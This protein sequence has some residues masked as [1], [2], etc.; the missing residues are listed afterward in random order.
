MWK[1]NSTLTIFWKSESKAARLCAVIR[2]HLGTD[3]IAANF[4]FLEL[5]H[6]LQRPLKGSL[7]L[8]ARLRDVEASL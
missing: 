6:R 5:S 8:R 3:D 4:V 7:G 2:P 1:S